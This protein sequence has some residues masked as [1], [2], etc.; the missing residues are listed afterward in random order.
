MRAEDERASDVEL[1]QDAGSSLQSIPR[2]R[3]AGSAVGPAVLIKGDVVYIR[4]VKQ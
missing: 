1:A 4:K 3:S 2:Y